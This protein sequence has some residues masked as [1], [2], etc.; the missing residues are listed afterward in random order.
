MY[1]LFFTTHTT[2]CLYIPTDVRMCARVVKK[3]H[4]N[5][6]II[7]SLGCIGGL[8]RSGITNSS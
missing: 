4:E 7:Y 5:R 3:E 2:L 8:V 6:V 1:Y